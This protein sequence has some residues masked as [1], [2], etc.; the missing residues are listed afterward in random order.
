[1][2]KLLQVIALTF[3]TF[4]CLFI[5]FLLWNKFPMLPA[6]F[7]VG[8]I[9]LPDIKQNEPH[10]VIRVVT[11][12][13]Q[14]GM[15]LEGRRT[16]N[17]NTWD[18]YE[19]LQ[20]I[21]D[22]LKEINA[23][24]VLLQEVDFHSRRSNNIDQSYFLAL[25]AEY[26][27]IAKAPHWKIKFLPDFATHIGPL[28]HGLA[29]LSRYPLIDNESRVF[30][31]PEEAPFYVRWLYSPH[32]GQ[33]TVAEIGSTNLT[34]INL[35]LEPWAQKTRE[36]TTLKV[37]HWIEEL[38]G[39]IV[40]GGDFNAIPPE[41]PLKTYTNLEDTPWFIDK[42]QWDLENDITI[43]AFRKLPTFSAAISVEA[44]LK[45]EQESFTYPANHPTQKLDYIFAGKGAEALKGYVF[46]KAGPASDHLPLVAEIR[47]Q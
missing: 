39:P 22:I 33:K 5:I 44:Y 43:N 17:L 31:L 27:Y 38:K 18:F 46:K 14:Y 42:K 45:N 34:I 21:A 12:N 19:R 7:K 30:K 47:L 23:D 26:P 36:K 15:G 4:L 24:I 20:K 28:E 6:K 32:G 35:H 25:K 40:V 8:I 41:A 10:G 13:I 2:K 16:E 9:H 29:V 11:Y 3:L 37:I 1:M